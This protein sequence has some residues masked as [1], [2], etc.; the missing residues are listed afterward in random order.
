M[1]PEQQS[2]STRPASNLPIK[3]KIPLVLF[4]LIFGSPGPLLFILISFRLLR[5][6]SVPTESMAPAINA[7]D[8]VFME[9]VSYLFREPRRGDIVVFKF[10]GIRLLASSSMYDKRVV[11]EP[12][13][14]IQISNDCLFVNSKLTT[15]SND[16]GPI[17]YKMPV[18][19]VGVAPLMS[20][21]QTNVN[22]PDRSYFV[23]GDRST[24]SFDS[25][26]FG[27]VPRKNIVGKVWFC[28]WPPQHVG[29]V[30]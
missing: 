6:F 9:G 2:A 16:F 3:R 30:K 20:V 19:P 18:F 27:P 10:D 23:V 17:T 24:N 21:P 22:V 26:F 29:F 15:I 5:P 28:Y 11:G 25:R 13:E 1:I 14:S 7:G 8:H 12:N 4:C